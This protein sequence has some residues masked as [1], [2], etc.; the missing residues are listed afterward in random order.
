M[1]LRKLKD[2]AASWHKKG[3]HDKALEAYTTLA[4]EEPQNPR[5]ALK[6]G[7]TYRK[8]GQSQKAMDAF[9]RA[10]R[11]YA[12]QGF[13]L[14]AIAMCNLILGIDRGDR[15]AQEMLQEF[16]ANR[17]G[18]QPALKMKELP[19]LPET[20]PVPHNEIELEAEPPEPLKVKK[21][22]TIPPGQ[23][24]DA[25]KLS[26]LLPDAR[27]QEPPPGPLKAISSDVFEIPLDLDTAVEEAFDSFEEI[28]IE[29]ELPPED[30]ARPRP[31]I[32]PT[33]LFS[34]LNAAALRS[35][36]QNAT[37]RHFTDGEHIVTQGEPGNSLFV[38]VDGEVAVIRESQ[39]RVELTRLQE[40]AFFG[41]I[42]VITRFQRTSTVEAAGEATVLEIS[43]EV[44]GGL[45]DEHPEVLKVL[46][47]FFRDRLIDT[48]VETSELFAPYA[49][50]DRK[51]LAR[52]FR[53]LEADPGTQFLT[54]GE[55]ADGLYIL[56]SGDLDAGA[57]GELGPGDLFGE[58]SLLT[59]EGAPYS[60]TAR[61]KCW[62][63]KLERRI[64]REVIMTHPVVLA[65]V[66]DVA[67]QRREQL[68][69]LK[70]QGP[71]PGPH[72]RVI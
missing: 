14:K 22:P 43:T 32:P 27:R 54:E 26:E 33:P 71:P 48:L 20:A 9:R 65:Y 6:T 42:A 17:L 34:S 3:R 24:L 38:L 69:Q 67:D 1:N 44:I 41:E 50:Q 28:A 63:L 4:R 15:E 66:S 25:V 70:E 53:F 47:K 37:V 39:P 35:V 56:L 5:W 46:L 49:K 30:E 10:A 12:E 16:H 58:T 55:R 45:I 68:Q 59:D 52:R 8:L 51:A 31:S 19:P 57:V 11:Q 40:G 7:E 13:M 2:R 61:T 60:V 36:V 64:F 62:V 72:L 21:T 18:A 23:A 29:A